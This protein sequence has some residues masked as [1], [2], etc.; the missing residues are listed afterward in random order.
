MPLGYGINVIA[1]SLSQYGYVPWAM[2]LS[3]YF[4]IETD[5]KVNRLFASNPM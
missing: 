3:I 1:V 4:A 5:M 2:K